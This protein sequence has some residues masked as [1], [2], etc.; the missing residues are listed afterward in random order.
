MDNDVAEVVEVI[1]G[2]RGE[3]GDF[4]ESAVLRRV[5]ANSSSFSATDWRRGERRRE[6]AEVMLDASLMSVAANVETSVSA[7]E[8]V[9]EED[10]SLAEEAD[11]NGRKCESSED[12]ISE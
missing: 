7:S 5:K 3:V 11:E 8:S 12:E 9:P 1:E 6:E 10:T 2:V 4:S